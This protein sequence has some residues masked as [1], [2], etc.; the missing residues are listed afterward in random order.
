MN[1]IKKI[2]G[3]LLII[4][5][6]FPSGGFSRV[7]HSEDPLTRKPSI[8]MKSQ[9]KSRIPAVTPPYK[10]KRPVLTNSKAK[11][12]LVKNTRKPTPVK[13]PP[14]SRQNTRTPKKEIKKRPAALQKRPA[15]LQK[16]PAA[17]QKRP[18]AL[19]KRP[20]TLQTS[21]KNPLFRQKNHHF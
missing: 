17:L 14:K 4:N 12:A 11:P 20:T 6:S 1:P 21:K 16:R 18:A 10:A 9:K 2:F 13:T 15:A 3:W 19:Q 7:N 5:L 8:L